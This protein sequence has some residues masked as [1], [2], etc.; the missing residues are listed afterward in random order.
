MQSPWRQQD[1][2]C[3]DLG[4][5]NSAGRCAQQW[6]LAIHAIVRQGLQG[7]KG[8]FGFR[9]FRIQSKARPKEVLWRVRILQVPSHADGGS[10]FWRKR[11]R[12]ASGEPLEHLSTEVLTPK[13][14]TV[15]QTILTKDL[16]TCG[17]SDVTVSWVEWM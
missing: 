4:V 2:P 5:L 15:G 12:A 3:Y 1:R 14:K 6:S 11:K 7:L 8:F 10:L 17:D 9:L 16:L 13:P